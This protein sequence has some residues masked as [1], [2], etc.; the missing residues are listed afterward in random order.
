MSVFVVLIAAI[1]KEFQLEP[2]RDLEVLAGKCLFLAFGVVRPEMGAYIQL[3]ERLY[4]NLVI[5]NRS[6]CSKGVDMLLRKL[7]RVLMSVGFLFAF[8]GSGAIIV[9]AEKPQAA[10]EAQYKKKRCNYDRDGYDSSRDEE[11]STGDCSGTVPTPEPISIILFTAGLAGIG[12]AA[13][14]HLR[15]TENLD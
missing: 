15:R 10:P 14:R 11:S 2:A 8:T 7:A 9:S 4:S 1:V 3:E 12:F 6:V 5:G 13:R